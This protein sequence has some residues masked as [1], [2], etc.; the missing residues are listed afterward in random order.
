MD[1]AHEHPPHYQIKVNGS[2][3]TVE[4]NIVT[5]DQAVRLAYP[6][7]DPNTIYSVTFEKAVNPREGELLKG[8]QVEIK[9]GTEF[10]VDDTGKS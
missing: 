4:S 1:K 9:S 8:Q 6:Q 3:A 7:P 10:D 5:F 2:H